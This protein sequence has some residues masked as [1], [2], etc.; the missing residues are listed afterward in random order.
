MSA[1]EEVD[2]ELAFHL[3]MRTREYVERG[4]SPGAA[5]DA[6]LRRFGDIEEVSRTCRRTAT[7]R[8]REMQ[9]AEWLA[10]LRQDVTFGLR[11]MAKGA[12]LHRSRGRDVGARHWGEHGGLQRRRRRP[13][14]RS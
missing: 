4:M 6:A 9:R 13:A 3:E 1:Q 12:T 10:E 2:D 7:R 8:D 5:R 11:Q 14:S